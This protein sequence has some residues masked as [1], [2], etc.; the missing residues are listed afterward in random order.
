MKKTLLLILF[1]FTVLFSCSCASTTHVKSFDNQLSIKG[2]AINT[3]SISLDKDIEKPSATD[4]AIAILLSPYIDKAIEDYYGER[5]QYAL[6]DAK[7]NSITQV[8]RN[9]VYKIIISVPTFHGPHNPPYG[10]E[11]MTF[12][13]KSGG[14]VTLD[15]YEHKDVCHI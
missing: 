4:S 10:L 5:T 7:V 14:L 11:I 12:T 6:Y 15:N 3:I 8:G 1:A 13:I 9:F 2:S